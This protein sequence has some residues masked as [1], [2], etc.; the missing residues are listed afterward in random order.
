MILDLNEIKYAGIV[1]ILNFD[2]YMTIPSSRVSSL[3]PNL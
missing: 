3:Q 1:A 2:Y